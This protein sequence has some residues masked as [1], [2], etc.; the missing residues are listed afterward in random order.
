MLQETVLAVLS[1]R[2]TMTATEVH[3]KVKSLR[4]KT[5]LASTRSTLSAL[6]KKGLV[7]SESRGDYKKVAKTKKAAVAKAKT[8]K[9]KATKQIKSKGSAG[10][11][12][13][14][15]SHGWKWS[16]DKLVENNFHLMGKKSRSSP[17]TDFDNKKGVYV[18]YWA[19]KPVYVGMTKDS[20]FSE[21]LKSHHRS[22]TKT[23]KWDHFSFFEIG[24]V[25]SEEA[26]ASIEL[27]LIAIL[28]PKLN[29]QNPASKT[30]VTAW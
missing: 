25:A 30:L 15:T 29:N 5:T 6:C 1:A 14:I 24:G 4:K 26:I 12:F 19:D 21:R 11:Q 16:R 7:I 13:F 8:Q 18:L 2:K 22:R 9:P 17:P 20:G 28:D 3:E 23:S 27:I 10:S